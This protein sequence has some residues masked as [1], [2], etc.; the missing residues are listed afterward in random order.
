[1]LSTRVLRRRCYVK[2]IDWGALMRI[3]VWIKKIIL[4]NNGVCINFFFFFNFFR[5]DFYWQVNNR[6]K[7]DERT[8][9]EGD[10]IFCRLWKDWRTEH[11]SDLTALMRGRITGWEIEKWLSTKTS[12]LI[13]LIPI[14]WIN[15]VAVTTST[16]FISGIKKKLI[17]FMM[18]LVC[19]KKKKENYFSSNFFIILKLISLFFRWN[20]YKMNFYFNL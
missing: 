8:H 19:I 14:G 5:E 12:C 9:A 17:R 4:T 15:P 3:I 16:L 6:V 13:K 10:K 11:L 20:F 2:M 18:T 1:M 7:I